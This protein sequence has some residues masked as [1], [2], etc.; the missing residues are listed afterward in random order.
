VLFEPWLTPTDVRLRTSEDQGERR[1][2]YARQA[3]CWYV[4]SLFS[5]SMYMCSSSHCATSA[6]VSEGTIVGISLIRGQPKR[7]KPR[8]LRNKCLRQTPSGDERKNRAQ[9]RAMEFLRVRSPHE[10]TR[11]GLRFCFCWVDHIPK[12]IEFAVLYAVKH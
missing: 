10:R 11:K 9:R 12:F 8:R 2:H 5:C 1:C 4:P 6:V 3:D 7:R